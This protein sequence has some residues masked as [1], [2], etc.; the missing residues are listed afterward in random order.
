MNRT[1]LI[2]QAGTG[3]AF[4]LAGCAAPVPHVPSVLTADVLPAPAATQPIREDM[5][6]PIVLKDALTNIDALEKTFEW[7][8]FRPGVEI[9]RIYNTPDGGPAAAFL[10]YQPGA[11]VPLHMHSGYEHIFILKG[12]Q[13]DRS[14]EHGPGTVVINPPGSSHQVTSPKGC[15]VLIV[16]DKPVIIAS[17]ANSK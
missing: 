17:E 12:T 1:R 8:P 16:W 14:G 13:M 5:M 4:L 9:A 7:K 6:S 10:K 2:L 11:S 15:I 3:L